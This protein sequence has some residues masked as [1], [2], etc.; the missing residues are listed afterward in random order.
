MFYLVSR[1]SETVFHKEY[2]HAMDPPVDVDS[3]LTSHNLLKG[4]LPLRFLLRGHL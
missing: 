1:Q 4:G 2:L 3:E